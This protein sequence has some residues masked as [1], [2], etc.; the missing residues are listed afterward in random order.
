MRCKGAVGAIWE[1]YE[2]PVGHMG[3]VW[4]P[5][6]TMLNPCALYIPFG[7]HQACD[8][9]RMHHMGAFGCHMGGV[10]H[11]MGAV[12]IR[13]EAYGAIWGPS[14]LWEQYFPM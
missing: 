4:E 11:W 8:R 12:H 14:A 10:C 1:P 7:S 9:I 13:W 5:C 3:T 6:G 2:S